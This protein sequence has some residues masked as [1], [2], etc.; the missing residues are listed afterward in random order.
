MDGEVAGEFAEAFASLPASSGEIPLLSVMPRDG[1][2]DQRLKKEALRERGPGPFL[3]QNFM[4]L[5]VLAKIKQF[6]PS[7]QMSHYDL[8]FGLF[9]RRNRPA[10]TAAEPLR[11]VPQVRRMKN[12]SAASGYAYEYFFEG[13]RD[14][15]SARE[16]FFTLSGDRK[17]WREF[18]LLL[19]AQVV[20]PWQ[21]EHERTLADNERYAVAKMSLFETF[22]R[23]ESPPLFPDSLAVTADQLEQIIDRIGLG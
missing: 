22:D 2:V 21:R 13:Y 3:F 20:E 8:V 14:L 15:G 7:L 19:P 17:N 16:Y 12:Y 10:E 9:K 4:R 1:H 6:D 18:R 23:I 11:G 5:E